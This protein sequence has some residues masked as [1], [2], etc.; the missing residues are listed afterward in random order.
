M[1]VGIAYLRGRRKH[2]RHSRRMRTR[3]FMYLARGP[4]GASSYIMIATASEEEDIQT[5]KWKIRSFSK[6][7]VTRTMGWNNPEKIS[8][9]LILQRFHGFPQIWDIQAWRS[10][11]FE[12]LTITV[13]GVGAKRELWYLIKVVLCCFVKSRWVM[14]LRAILS[15]CNKFHTL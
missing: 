2:S 7:I 5:L 13:T 6:R 14:S 15:L 10:A 11:I 8:A 3:N 1:H 4:W 12:N 9:T